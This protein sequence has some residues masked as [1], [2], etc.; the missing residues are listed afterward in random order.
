MKRLVKVWRENGKGTETKKLNKSFERRS[1]DNHLTLDNKSESD[2]KPSCSHS[3]V[4][5]VEIDYEDQYSSSKD[6]DTDTDFKVPKKVSSNNWQMRIQI[7]FTALLSDRYGVSDRATAT[8]A[9]SVLHD[10]GLI[11]DSDVSHV[12]DKNKI[13]REKQNVR[14]EF[15]SKSDEFPLQGLYLDGRKDD[16]LVIDLAH[17]KRFRRVKKEER[18]S[19]IHQ[20]S[21]YVCSKFDFYLLLP[22]H[23]KFDASSLKRTC[24][25]LTMQ[26]R[27]PR[28][29]NEFATSSP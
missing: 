17:S 27:Y 16:A 18:Y 12:I 26:N 20:D 10:V 5:I 15:C 4:N 6:S 1:R 9:S 29:Q 8:I 22:C 23:G 2:L 25:K 3:N 14:V 11:T 24:G 19:L 28:L 13:R 7:K 21:T